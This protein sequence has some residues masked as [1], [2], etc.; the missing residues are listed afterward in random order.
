MRALGLLVFA[1]CGRIGFDSIDAQPL[2][3]T[4]TGRWTGACHFTIGGCLDGMYDE[5]SA[6]EAVDGTI[7]G[8]YQY[9]DASRT[10]VF[11]FTGLRTGDMVELREVPGPGCVGTHALVRSSDA[12]VGTWTPDA[13]SPCATCRCDESFSPL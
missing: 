4:F 2:P 12:W 1:A 3:Q 8:T 6:I 9:T 11:S 5:L 13:T 10:V 7:T